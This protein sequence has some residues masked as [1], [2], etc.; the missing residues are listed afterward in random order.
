MK[1]IITILEKQDYYWNMILTGKSKRLRKKA[2]SM[3]SKYMD[4]AD[5]IMMK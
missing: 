1:D 4:E 3:Y 2:V 5:K